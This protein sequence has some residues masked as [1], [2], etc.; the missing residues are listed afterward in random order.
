MDLYNN[1]APAFTAWVVANKLLHEPLVIGVYSARVAVS[2]PKPRG[3]P[4]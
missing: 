4:S 3:R 2:G 1:E